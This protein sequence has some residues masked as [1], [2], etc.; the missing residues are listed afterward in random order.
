MLIIEPL[1]TFFE[2]AITLLLEIIKG[3]LSIG[4]AIE[5][6]QILIVA[7]VLGVSVPIAWVIYKLYGFIKDHSN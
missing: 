7:G 5:D 2:T 3:M 4:G 1:I 6:A